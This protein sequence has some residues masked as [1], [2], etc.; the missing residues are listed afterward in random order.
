MLERSLPDAEPR[1]KELAVK[2]GIAESAEEF[3]EKIR[4]LEKQLD[5]PEHF[6][7]INKAD[8]PVMIKRIISEASLQ[9]CPKKLS[10][11]EIRSILDTLKD[12]S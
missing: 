3:I 1:L 2:S 12:R 5:I 4:T 11:D 7:E 8:Y 10:A 6:E 9:G